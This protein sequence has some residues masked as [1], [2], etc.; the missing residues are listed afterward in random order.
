MS[1]DRQTGAVPQDRSRP[2][3]SSWF[4]FTELLDGLGIDSLYLVGNSFDGYTGAY[5][6]M[7]LPEPIANW[8]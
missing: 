2:W 4:W 8:F 3:T 1:L 7:K 6:A 5:D